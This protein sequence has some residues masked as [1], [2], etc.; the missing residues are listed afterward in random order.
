ME[1]SGQFHNPATY[2][3][4]GVLSTHGIGS[5]LKSQIG[6]LWDGKILLPLLGFEPQI[7]QPADYTNYTIP[8]IR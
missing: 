3:G 5:W 1:V 6:H 8:A 2:S 7:I 4:K